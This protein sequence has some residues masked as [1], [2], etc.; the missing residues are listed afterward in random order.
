MAGTILHSTYGMKTKGPNDPIVLNLKDALENLGKA[1]LASNFL[2]NVFPALKRIPDWFPWTEWKRTARKWRDHKNNAVDTPYYWT[3]SQ[4]A[5]PEHEPSM[6]ESVLEQTRRMGLSPDE[7]DDYAKEIAFV[8][9]AGG[10]DTTTNTI[11]VFFVAMILFPETQRKA[12]AEIDAVIGSTRLPEMEDRSQLPYMHQLI[13]ELLRW[14]PIVPAGLAHVCYQ[15][16]VYKGYRIPKGAIMA[17]NHNPKVY[18]DPQLF[19]PDRFADPSMPRASTFGFGRRLC[20]GSHFAEASL[21]IF[22]SSIIATFN[23]EMAQDEHGNNLVPVAESE[24]SMLFHPVPFKFK[25]SIRSS[26]HEQ[27]IRAGM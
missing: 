9:F 16:D 20:Q 18:K 19:N 7:A 23:I 12:Q 22:I 1:V 5:L 6:I 10:T 25:L 26:A 2:V 14:R 13:Q 17:I 3:K 27:L 15:D 21:F 24:N 4:I 11:L 8:L